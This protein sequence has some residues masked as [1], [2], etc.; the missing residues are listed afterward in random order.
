VGSTGAVPVT[1]MDLRDFGGGLNL[2]DSAE[3]LALNET[4]DAVNATLARRG[5]ALVRNGCAL[6]VT[7]PAGTASYLYY[8]PAL[9]RWYCQ[10]GTELYRRPGD[11]SG[12]WTDITT[13][14]LTTVA[15]VAMCDF[16]DVVVICHPVDGVYTHDGGTGVITN[17]ST[18]A[19]GYAIAVF[20]NRVWVADG[21]RLWYSDLGSSTV[22]T[23]AT[24]FV[25][26]REKDDEDIT[27][28][29]GSAG[30]LLAFKKRSAYRVTDAATGAY[31]TIDWSNGCVG[32]RAIT[33]LRGKAYGWGT[34]SI[35]SWDGVGAGKEIGDK[36][37]PLFEC[38]TGDPELYYDNVSVAAYNGRVFFAYPQLGQTSAGAAQSLTDLLELEPLSGAIMVH[39]LASDEQFA[40]LVAKG[41]RLFSA[42]SS[43]ANLYE[44]FSGTPG[45]DNS[46][47]YTS[48]Y[49]TPPL[50]LGKLHQLQRVRVY[51]KA[52][53]AGTSTK[54]LRTYK[55]WSPSVADTFDITT[56]IETSDGEEAADLQGLGHAEAFQLEFRVT[57]GTG[58][59]ELDRLLL[60]LTPVAR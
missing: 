25:D 26:V 48:Y 5:A 35:Y 24:G 17:R 8:S 40:A 58:S 7:L 57:G 52:H 22:Y 54:Q 23:T 12:S 33:S 9:D 44:L 49:K 3:Q 18:T 32:P 31:Q 1:V 51:G 21:K 45:A 55:D 46:V 47:N 38:V 50:N 37:T 13:V 53:A 11:L 29:A 27:A 30:A 10:V 2:R 16:Q 59:A 34:D 19:K 15:P 20:K 6:A 60:D 42:L 14:S 28:L 56:P 43:S 4:P 36:V 39:R 41:R